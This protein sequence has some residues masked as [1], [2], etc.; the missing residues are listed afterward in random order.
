MHPQTSTSGQQAGQDEYL[1]L[2][3][4][5]S[6]RASGIFRRLN[7]PA[8]DGGFDSH[9]AAAFGAAR[10]AGIAQP[11]L[12]GAIP[13]DLDQP[14]Q[15]FIPHEARFF[16]RAERLAAAMAG[17]A[18]RGEVV[19][20]SSM[21]DEQGFKAAVRQAIANFQHSEIKKAVLSRICELRFAQPVAVDAIFDALC[22]QNP[23]GYQFR[24]PMLDG[25]SLIGV[26]PELLLRKSGKQILTFPL[27][28]SAKRQADAAQDEAVGADLLASAKDHYEH[29]LVID[30]IRRVL[31]PHCQALD[32]PAAPNLL[33]TSAM[34]HLG[35]R[36]DGELADGASSSLGLA[37]QLHPTPAV[38]GYPTALSRK[39]INLIEPFERGVFSGMVGWCD[40]HGDGEWVVTIRCATIQQE[41]VRLFAGAGIVEAS[42][43][44]AEWAETQAKL[45]TMLG[46][47]GLTAAEALA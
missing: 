10:A 34:W 43:P 47:F 41:T 38:C 12:M 11:V 20:A 8:G 4:H 26:S 28:G 30:E 36:I 35:T 46:A 39:L 31:A 14:S 45:G 37:C 33:S 3:G 24:L 5:R 2:S 17:K 9:V 13:F 29:S 27:A 23:H 44:E 1:F 42:S 16:D 21:P 40:E 15:L 32:V 25:S 19:R 22:R 18:A 7:T 6:L